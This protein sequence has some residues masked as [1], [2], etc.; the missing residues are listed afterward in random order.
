MY[1]DLDIIYSRF[2]NFEKIK[3][4]FCLKTPPPVE[5]TFDGSK[6][7]K[8][9]FIASQLVLRQ[10]R[11]NCITAIDRERFQVFYPLHF[12]SAILILQK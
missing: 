8:S 9:N 4:S 6:S 10:Q 5:F 3:Q 12:N 1:N 2:Y 7:P 11:N